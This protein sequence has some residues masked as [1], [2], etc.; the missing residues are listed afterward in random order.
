M[1]RLDLR[2]EPAV[3]VKD[4]DL[5]MRC[6]KA[7]FSMRRKTLLNSL[8]SIGYQ[9]KEILSKALASAGIDPTRRAETL[10]LEEFAKLSDSLQEA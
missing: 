9:D 3:V 1:L 2:D 10:T 4:E 7:G 6:I 5:M 8:T